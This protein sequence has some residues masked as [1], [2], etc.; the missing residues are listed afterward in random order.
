MSGV[1][2][3]AGADPGAR[4]DGDFT[5]LH[6]A[7][8]KNPEPSVVGALIEGGADPNARNEDGRTPLHVAAWKNPEPSVVEALI[9]VGAD[10]AARDERGRIPFDYAKRNEALRGTDVYRRLSEARPRRK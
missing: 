2:I 3:K 10:P 4:A 9:E 7:A 1:L 8:W 6:F 5:P